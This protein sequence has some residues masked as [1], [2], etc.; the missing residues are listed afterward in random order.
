MDYFQQA[1][2]RVKD[3]DEVIPAHK[4][5]SMNFTDLNPHMN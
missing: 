1:F 2:F 5:T 4:M 3:T